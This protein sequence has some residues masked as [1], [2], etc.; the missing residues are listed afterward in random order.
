MP[1]TLAVGPR[2]QKFLGPTRV[3][4]VCASATKIRQ[5]NRIKGGAGFRLH[6]K[7]FLLYVVALCMS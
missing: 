4:M 7:V 5:G 6:H 2:V 1:R 3:H